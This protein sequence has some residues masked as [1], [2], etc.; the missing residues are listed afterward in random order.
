[1]SDRTPLRSNGAT[2]RMP[3]APTSTTAVLV[4]PPPQPVRH[5]CRTDLSTIMRIPNAA[6][7][8]TSKIMRMPD[9]CSERP[10]R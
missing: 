8:K 2:I 10:I 3:K 5:Q 7:P 9:A 6:V 4:L 1:M